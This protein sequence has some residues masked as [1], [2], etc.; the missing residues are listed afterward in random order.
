[1]DACVVIED[2]LPGLTAARAAGM[3]CVML[4][5]NHPARTLDGRGAALLWDSFAGHNVGELAAL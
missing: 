2:S 1:V 5:T 4:T 3:A